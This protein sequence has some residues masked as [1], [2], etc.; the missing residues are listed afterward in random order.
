[1]DVFFA[2]FFDAFAVFFD[3][4]AF[5]AKFP[6]TQS[7]SNIRYACSDYTTIAKLISHASKR[8]NGRHDAACNR[9]KRFD[10][11]S[12]TAFAGP[13]Q[14]RRH[15]FATGQKEAKLAAFSL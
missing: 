4:F 8:V 5:L 13:K 3:F 1:L 12:S 2:V 15:A 9:A 10:Y 11:S 7:K 14:N 6:S